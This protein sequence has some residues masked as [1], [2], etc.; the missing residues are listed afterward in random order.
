MTESMIVEV[1]AAATLLVRG[2]PNNGV[3][4]KLT[5]RRVTLGPPRGF[6]FAISIPPTGHSSIGTGSAKTNACLST[7]TRS[8]WAKVK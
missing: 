4:I 2:G 8:S 3:I 6:V 7:G 1:G 5:G